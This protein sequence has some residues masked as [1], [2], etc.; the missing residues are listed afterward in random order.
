M[1]FDCDIAL[2]ELD[3]TGRDCSTRVTDKELA[4]VTEAKAVRVNRIEDSPL[5]GFLL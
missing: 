5:H 3:F 1:I 2:A 4:S